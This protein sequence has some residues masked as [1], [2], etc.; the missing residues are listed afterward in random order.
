MKNINQ[1]ISKTPALI[2]SIKAQLISGPGDGGSSVGVVSG[3]VATDG[4]T[5]GIAWLA[6]DVLGDLS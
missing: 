5:I 2:A 4:A 6:L 3:G 1:P